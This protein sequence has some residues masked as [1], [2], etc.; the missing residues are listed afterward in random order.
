M[1]G[2]SKFNAEFLEEREIVA[3]RADVHRDRFRAG[4]KKAVRNDGDLFAAENVFRRVD[5]ARREKRT[6]VRVRE[7]VKP[8]QAIL[9]RDDFRGCADSRVKRNV[10]CLADTLPV[11]DAL[12]RMCGNAGR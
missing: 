6:A 9:I 1:F 7:L 10:D 4:C 11:R 3:E 2:N 12:R 8:L 5:E